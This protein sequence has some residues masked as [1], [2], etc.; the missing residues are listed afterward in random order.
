MKIDL[1]YLDLLVKMPRPKPGTP[2]FV[3][4]NDLPSVSRHTGQPY[5]DYTLKTY[6]TKLNKLALEGITTAAD[7]SQNQEKAIKIAKAESASDPHKMRLF[8]SA[9]FYALSGL[10]NEAKTKI[11]E[12]FKRNATDVYPNK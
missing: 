7:L 3:L 6:T 11:Y 9:M 1:K 4:P 2:T 12:E 10:P 5:S 8:L